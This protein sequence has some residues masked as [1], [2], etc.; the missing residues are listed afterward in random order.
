M[1]LQK[2]FS[3][4]LLAA[5][6]SVMLL[7]VLLVYKQVSLEVE[8]EAYATCYKI[9]A[10]V[11]ASRTYVREQLRP[12]MVE[13]VGTKDFIPEAMSGSFVARELFENFLTVY[14]DYV[15]KFAS[16][17]PRNQVNIA[18]DNERT[19]IEKFTHDLD[20]TEWQGLITNNDMQYVTVAKP[21]RF[22][23][24]CLRCHGIPQNAPPDLISLYGDKNGFGAKEGDVTIYSIGVPYN[25]TFANIWEKSV[26]YIFLISILSIFT[27]LFSS[28]LFNN[29]SKSLMESEK[30]Y[31]NAAHELKERVKELDCFYGISKLTEREDITIDLLFQG[32][33]KLLPLAWRYPE[34]TCVQI[35]MGDQIYKTDNFTKTLWRQSQKIAVYGE[36]I[37]M[38]DVYY[39]EEKQETD[40]GPFIAEERN[41]INAVS[42][43]L[44]HL[45]EK[46]Q[47][48]TERDKLETQLRQTH[49]MEAIGTLSGGIA[50]DFNNLLAAILG[51]ADMAKDD[52]SDAHPA[53]SSIEQVLIAGNRAKDIVK[54]ILSF[55]RKE[56]PERVPLQLD[57]IVTRGR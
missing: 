18:N 46:M 15:I 44:G 24:A 56:V 14:P 40:E 29:L 54:Q 6:I 27:F 43:R 16:L 1:D 51:Y 35:K 8:K 11:G 30:D 39:L 38:I 25:I 36:D 4:K 50:H 20:L 13:L 55:S 52:L 22:K 42:K 12:K 31:K 57:V 45:I 32:V 47:T 34:I 19:I 9:L 7:V 10:Y 33:T 23:K 3:I 2:R 28:K 5:T 53:R 48:E 21:F 49:K 26:S 41:L 17:N 37:G